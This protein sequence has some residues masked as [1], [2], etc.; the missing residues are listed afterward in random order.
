MDSILDKH[1][2]YLTI[3]NQLLSNSTCLRRSYGAVIV[4]YDNIIATGYN[5]SPIG[6][7]KCNE[8]GSCIR[9]RLQIPRGQRYELCKSVH[10]EANA[11]LQAPRN[12]LNNATLYLSG[13][14]R[15]TMLCPKNIMPCEICKKLIINSGIS[16]VIV[17]GNDYGAYN[18]YLVKDWK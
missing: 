9:E 17:P 12:M 3:C 10:A 5:A 13:I 4:K 8:H 14:D 2:E 6:R 15:N 16:R 1:F 7:K 11:I 18:I